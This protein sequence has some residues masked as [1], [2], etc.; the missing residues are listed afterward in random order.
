ML[1]CFTCKS[2][3]HVSLQKDTSSGTSDKE[4]TSEGVVQNVATHTA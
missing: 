3:H 4:T 2:A 1:R